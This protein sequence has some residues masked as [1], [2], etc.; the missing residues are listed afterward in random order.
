M[1]LEMNFVVVQQPEQNS[2]GPR[3]SAK[4]PGDQST[5]KWGVIGI[6]ESIVFLCFSCVSN[7]FSGIHPHKARGSLWA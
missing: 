4:G 2:R 6:L 3:M 1:A 7:F 5:K